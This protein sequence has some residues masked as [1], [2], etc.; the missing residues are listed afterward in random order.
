MRALVLALLA[1][2]AASAAPE[3]S[4]RPEARPEVPLGAVV[5]RAEVEPVVEPL[6]L[7]IRPEARPRDIAAR[8]RSARSSVAAPP[9]VAG[10]DPSVRRAVG[11]VGALCGRRAILGEPLA[12]IPGRLR[13]CGIREPMR[14]M[15]VSGVRLSR[16][17]V[18]DCG[19]ARALAGWVEDAVRP[20]IGESG[21]GV[22]GLQVAAGYQCRTRNNRPGARISEH[23]RGRAIDISA[24]LLADGQR[25]TVLEGWGRQGEGRILRAIHRAACGPFGTVLGPQADRYHRDHFHLDTT[26]RRST[27]YCR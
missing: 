23:G 21:G 14:V 17:A 5:E 15:Q 4:P 10:A 27:A 13:G 8:A 6:A 24:F 12:P 1:A 25:I 22:V 18:M 16:P 20:A 9:R 2:G 26:P 7:S 3:T 19:T 11:P